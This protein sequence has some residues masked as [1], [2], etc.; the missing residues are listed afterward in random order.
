MTGSRCRGIQL[1]YFREG[2]ELKVL[3]TATLTSVSARGA[4]R[5]FDCVLFC[6][7]AE[8]NFTRRVLCSASAAD[9]GQPFVSTEA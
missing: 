6:D 8:L 9:V 7:V 1:P 4:P 5:Q 3:E 2:D